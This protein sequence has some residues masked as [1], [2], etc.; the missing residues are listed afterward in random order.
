VHSIQTVAARDERRIAGR[1]LLC[2]ER[3]GSATPSTLRAASTLPRLRIW[4]R[5]DLR[6]RP[7]RHRGNK[8]HGTDE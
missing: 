3:L 6:V 4:R 8:Q 1:P 7:D 2:G 5:R